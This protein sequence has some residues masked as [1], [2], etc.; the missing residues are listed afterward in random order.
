MT[1]ETKTF[2]EAVQDLQALI[3]HARLA[4]DMAKIENPTARGM[5]GVGWKLPDGSGK[6]VCDFDSEPLCD[7]LEM[8]LKAL[9]DMT[10]ERKRVVMD[11]FARGAEAMRSSCRLVADECREEIDQL[12]VPEWPAAGGDT[13]YRDRPPTLEEVKALAN[14]VECCVREGETQWMVLQ[15]VGQTVSA[16]IVTIRV[17]SYD[18]DIKSACAQ[19]TYSFRPVTV[20][21]DYFPWPVLWSPP[22]RER[23]TTTTMRGTSGWSAPRSPCTS[24]VAPGGPEDTKNK[25]DEAVRVLAGV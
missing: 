8:V 12:P 19:D 2:E 11:A 16:R 17:S 23:N 14:T 22:A 4:V 25:F 6:L 3:T 5:A 9:Q 13:D 1:Q 21:G 20:T 24:T 15:L 10:C 7:D 18:I